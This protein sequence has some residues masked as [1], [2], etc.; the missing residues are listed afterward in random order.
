[1]K[2]LLAVL[3]LTTL[4]AAPA[5]AGYRDVTKTAAPS[6][7]ISAA[8]SE[9]PNAQEYIDVARTGQAATVRVYE[10]GG[11]CRDAD[12]VWLD[13]GDMGYNACVREA[14]REEY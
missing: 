5:N 4:A 8:G 2:S 6:S 1:M 13:K 9:K 3:F 10:K 12:G 11:R 7:D 14:R